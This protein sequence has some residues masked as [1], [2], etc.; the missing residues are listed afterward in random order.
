M[1]EIKKSEK[2]KKNRFVS[3]IKGA[4]ILLIIYDLIVFIAVSFAF[5]FIFKNYA[6]L[7]IV[8]YLW[9]S[10]VTFAIILLCRT[11]LSIYVQIWR[12][13]GIRSY[14]SLIFADAIALVLVT[15][16]F[17]FIEPRS[18]LLFRLAVISHRLI[19]MSCP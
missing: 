9:Q 18:A 15:V 6:P 8:A 16:I 3:L 12:Y 19:I 7:D 4:K 5:Y 11:F 2:T 1:S 13:G 14:M 17:L 10:A